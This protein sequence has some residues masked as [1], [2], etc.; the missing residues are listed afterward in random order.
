MNM[1]RPPQLSLLLRITGTRGIAR[2]YLVVNGFDGALTMLGIL[3]GFYVSRAAD[4]Q[5]VIS[6]CGGAAVALGMSG[7]SSAYVSERA[8]RRLELSRLE[9]AMMEDLGESAHGRAARWVPVFIA[10][11]NGLAP[12]LVSVIIISPLVLAWSGALEFLPSMRG[13]IG[14]A[15]LT[16]FMLGVFLGRIGSTFWLISGLQALIIALGTVGLIVVLGR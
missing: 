6:A 4:L 3:M 10:M 15:L 16:V 2:R 13:A 12:L 11:V 9:D 1:G 7:L 5:V 14:M 8:E